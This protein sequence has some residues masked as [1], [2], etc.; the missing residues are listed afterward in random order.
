MLHLRFFVS[1]CLKIYIVLNKLE[2]SHN[3]NIFVRYFKG[4]CFCFLEIQPPFLDKSEFHLLIQKC[5]LH[6][7]S[8]K[9]R[10]RAVWAEQRKCGVSFRF[11]V[12]RYL[13]EDTCVKNFISTG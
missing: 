2:F 12:L 5:S 11:L 1:V 3:Q 4:F 6:F 7:S 9:L 8:T 10:G 13:R